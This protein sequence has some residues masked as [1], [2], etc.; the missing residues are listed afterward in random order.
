MQNEYGRL[1]VPAGYVCVYFAMRSVIDGGGW[2]STSS[3]SAPVASNA[4]SARASASSSVKRA[5]N[6]TTRA[7]PFGTAIARTRPFSST[8]AGIPSRKTSTTRA[9]AAALGFRLRRT[10]YADVSVP[11]ARRTSSSGSGVRL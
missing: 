1:N 3:R 10:S 8:T 5:P 6:E 4:F 7:P 2:I 9:V 11:G